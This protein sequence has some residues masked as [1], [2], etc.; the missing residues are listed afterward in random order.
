MGG[1]IFQ[2]GMDAFKD[3]YV[4]QRT[5]GEDRQRVRGARALAAG[6]RTQAAAEFGAGGL[7]DDVRGVQRDQEV[8]DQLGYTR[9]RQAHADDQA[10]AEKRIETLKQIAQGLKGVPPGQRKGA[11]DHVTPIFQQ[12]GMDPSVFANLTEDQL[13]DQSLDMFSGELEKQWQAVNLGNGGFAQHNTR[14]GEFKMQREPDKIVV[15][16]NG[17]TAVTADGKPIARNP[18]V[19]APPRASSGGGSAALPPG[20]VP[21]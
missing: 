4:T 11:L 13:T 12:I 6:D 14:T 7:T 21:R 8:Q 2:T 16:P 9:D 1:N 17:A 18:K 5:M 3:S 19:F 20:Y 10:A 15:L